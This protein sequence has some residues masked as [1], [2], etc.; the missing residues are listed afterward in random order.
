VNLWRG[1][2]LNL[3]SGAHD[4]RVSYSHIRGGHDGIG[5]NTSENNVTI[6]HNRIENFAD[7]CME[8]EGTTSVGRISVYENYLGNCLTAI[9][10]GQDTPS[11]PGPLLV[12]RN[13]VV[14]LR[15]AYVNRK[16]GINSWNGGGRFGYEYMFKHGTGSTYSTRNAHYYHNTLVMLNSAGKGI[17]ITPKYPDDARLANNLMIMVNGVVNGAYRTGAGMVWNGDLYWKMNT[18][19]SAH[20][21]SSY[22]TV[23]SFSSATGFERNGIGSVSR[24]GTNPQFATFSPNVVDK[25]QSVWALRADSESFRPSDFLLGAGSPAIGTGIVIPP[26]PVLGTL[27]DTRSSRD[28]GAI[29]FGTPASE[30][31]VFPFNAGGR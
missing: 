17:N 13:T 12:Y 14:L 16:A 21:L 11:F 8:L 6:D 29:P 2:T 5:T 9:A 22:D 19:D 30:Y 25:T 10:P 27:P 1:T 24:R 4:V 28:I 7:D 23:S 3:A 31:D 20:L 18:V 26:H 15:N